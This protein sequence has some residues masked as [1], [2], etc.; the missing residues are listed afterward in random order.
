MASFSLREHREPRGHQEIQLDLSREGL[1]D[2]TV[3]GELLLFCKFSRWRVF[4]GPEA[5]PTST[6]NDWSSIRCTATEHDPFFPTHPKYRLDEAIWCYE[7]NTVF[8]QYL[9]SQGLSLLVSCRSTKDLPTLLSM[10][11]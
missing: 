6:R 10:S 9:L 11:Q 3:H 8:V 2:T 5:M 7:W 1:T 4:K